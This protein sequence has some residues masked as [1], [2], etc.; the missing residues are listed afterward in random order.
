[1]VGSRG[2]P[3]NDTKQAVE[4]VIEKGESRE[5]DDSVDRVATKRARTAEEGDGP[6]VELKSREVV[7]ERKD[8]NDDLQ[9][10]AKLAEA[11]LK[12]MEDQ[13]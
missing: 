5:L 7:A 8:V 6:K 2:D 13:Y 9:T 12:A 11:H 1:M 4:P 10:T 3:Q